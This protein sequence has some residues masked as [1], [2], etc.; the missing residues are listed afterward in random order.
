MILTICLL[1]FLSGNQSNR[2]VFG[3]RVSSSPTQSPSINSSSP[4]PSAT[5][6][7]ERHDAPSGWAK[8]ELAP[9]LLNFL[10]LVVIAIQAVIYGKQLRVMREQEGV[11]EKQSETLEKQVQAMEAQL[12]AIREQALIMADSLEETRNI[13]GHNERSVRAAEQAVEVAQQNMIYAQ[14]AY[15]SITSGDVNWARFLLRIENSG[16][17]PANN[18]EILAL[19]DVRPA[20][21]PTPG[22]QEPSSDRFIYLGL[23]A[24]SSYFE[25]EVRL[26]TEISDE[27]RP[28]IG[29]GDLKLWCSGL[30]RYLDV[31]GQTRHTK[32]CFYQRYGNT[33]LQPWVEGN[34]GD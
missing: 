30:I 9:V 33:N 34:E 13:V 29:R 20:P 26:T 12:M 24:P 22:F 2:S 6:D 17:T 4:L 18:V 1:V 7:R 5:L 25:R 27:E 31:F 32:F 16:N 28:L 10:L 21:L 19:A 3:E 11:L 15:V 8:F 23:I 14:R